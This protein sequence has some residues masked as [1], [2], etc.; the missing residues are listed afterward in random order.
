MELGP[1][2]PYNSATV[3]VLIGTAAMVGSCI[4]SFLN[5][6]IYRLPLGKNLAHPGSHCP[7]CGHAIRPWHNVPI[8]GWMILGGRCRDC[9]RPISVRYPLVEFGVAMIFGG[10]AA[11]AIRASLHLAAHPNPEFIQLQLFVPALGRSILLSTLL[12]AALIEY[13]GRVVTSRLFIPT[14]VLSL[15]AAVFC[16]VMQWPWIISLVYPRNG[17][18]HNFEPWILAIGGGLLGMLLGSIHRKRDSYVELCG[19]AAIGATLGPVAVGVIYAVYSLYRLLLAVVSRTPTEIPSAA[20][21]WNW[22]ML[23]VLTALWAIVVW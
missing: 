17:I 16:S 1:T 10:L 21:Q 12:A 6:V 2:L 23:A 20:A 7:N 8:L 15:A 5:V 3:A 19:G 22:L 13:D 14:L 9:R 18:L 11:L 4:G